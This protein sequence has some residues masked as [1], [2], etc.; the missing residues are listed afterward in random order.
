[1]I[2]FERLFNRFGT[3]RITENMVGVTEKG[4]CRVW[5]NENFSLN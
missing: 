5:I 4:F 2:G 1:M 3:F